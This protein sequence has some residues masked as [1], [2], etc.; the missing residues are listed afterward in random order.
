MQDGI[1]AC[2]LLFGDIRHKMKKKNLTWILFLFT[3]PL[4]LFLSCSRT[5]STGLITAELRFGFTTEP[6]TL[7]P[8]NPNNTADGRSILFNVF[9]G[10]VKP[11]TDGS[12][13]PC[14][15]KSWTIEQA[16][17]VYNFTLRENVL[18]H[19]SSPV[20]AA[21]I[22]FSLETAQA[23]GFYGLEQIAQIIIRDENTIS[24]ILLFP[25]PD[26]TPY[27]TVGIVKADNDDRGKNF[28]GTGP[29]YIESS[30]PQRELVL[31][32]F[33][34]YWQSGIPYFEK[35][36]IVF[37]SNYDALMIALI[38]GSID[39]ARLTGSMA[40]QLDP[41]LFD[42]FHS[43]SA[44]VHL[45]AL[46]NAVPRLN[47][48]RVRKALNYG[49]DVQNI[50]DTAFFGM[51]A[52]S[53]SPLIPGLSIYYENSS[54]YPYNPDT[55]RGLLAEAGYGKDN[56]L[57]LEITVA[58]SYSMHVDTAQVITEQLKEIGVNARIKLVDWITWVN[59]V[60]GGRQYE[61]TVISLDSPSI[62]PKSSLSRYH[63][64]SGINFVN[65][66]APDFD[67]IYDS[68][69]S[70]T[71]EAARIQ[72]YKEAQHAIVEN[73]ASVFIQDIYFLNVFK[74]GLYNGVLNYPLYVTDFASIYRIVKN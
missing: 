25:D 27:M 30:T 28:I 47:D 61:A 58:S 7:D 16:G 55:A 5:N 39:G 57:P 35:V 20:T 65:F 66:S 12:L 26:F 10:L 50:I 13:L 48:I 53:R 73:A 69:L 8:L 22:K 54:S 32:K 15:A 49:I 52:P 1:A 74:G 43:Y 37:F 70:E 14:I 17:L 2:G 34:D 33:K 64:N 9:E 63:T 21:D 42:I 36:T 31:K 6:S 4:I 18:F 67:K 40:A 29:F 72:L 60:Y 19:D 44:A 71:D 24:V 59:D 51:G 41:E 46:N 45:L 56:P 68:I 3:L 62:S 11:G 38:G 23:A